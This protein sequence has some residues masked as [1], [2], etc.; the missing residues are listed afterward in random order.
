M[1]NFACKL[2]VGAGTGCGAEGHPPVV[3]L[4][5]RHHLLRGLG[6][7]LPAVTQ[8]K[9]LLCGAVGHGQQAPHQ[10]EEAIILKKTTNSLSHKSVNLHLSSFLKE[11]TDEEGKE[12]QFLHRKWRWS[13][14]AAL[15]APPL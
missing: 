7:Q 2:K 11:W 15:P 13:R 3:P 10:L 14:P 6:L 12:T 1:N 9:L 8:D 5:R 4:Q